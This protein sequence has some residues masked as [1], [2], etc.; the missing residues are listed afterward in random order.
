MVY[1][2]QEISPAEHI[3]LYEVLGGKA[4]GKVAIKLSTGEP[5]GKNS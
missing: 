4:E 5:E 3:E 2:S 1:F